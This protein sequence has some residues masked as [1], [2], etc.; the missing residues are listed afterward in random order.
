M[1]GGDS[2]HGHQGMSCP[3]HEMCPM[4]LPQVVIRA[5]DIEGGATLSF[6][7]SGDV[8]ALRARVHK[9]AQMHEHRARPPAVEGAPAQ[10]KPDA[11]PH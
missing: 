2:T 6:T 8:A 1:H 9:L 10:A 5:Q 7:T 11:T 4:M 3:M